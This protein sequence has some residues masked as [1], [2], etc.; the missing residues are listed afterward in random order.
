M[1]NRF[2]QA[3]HFMSFAALIPENKPTQRCLP[4]LADRDHPQTSLVPATGS[5]SVEQNVFP[6]IS[7]SELS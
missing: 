6:E 3:A 5:S 1:P 4:A 7:C 2:V